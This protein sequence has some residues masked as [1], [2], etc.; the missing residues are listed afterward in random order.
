LNAPGISHRSGLEAEFGWRVGGSIRLSA[1]YALLHAT[2]P[3]G[4]SGQVTEQRRPKHSGSIALDGSCGKITYGASIAYVGAHLDQRDV[5]PF[6]VVRLRAYWLGGARV[7]YEI[8]PGVEIF[9][10]AANLFDARFEDVSGYRTEG[11]S[12]YAGI[13]LSGR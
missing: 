6:D 7:A 11:R 3:S 8:S 9:G 10:R 5:P 1:N 4:E 2:Q 13:R 12:L